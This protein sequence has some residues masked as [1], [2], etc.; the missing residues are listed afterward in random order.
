MASSYAVS[1]RSLTKPSQIPEKNP[2]IIAVPSQVLVTGASGF[3]GAQ[4]V[5]QLLAKG[6]RVR[7]TVR[8]AGKPTGLEALKRVELFTADLLAQG[9]FD[10]A[11]YRC[12]C[13]FHTASPYTLDT[14]NPQGDLV[15][16]AVNGTVNVLTACM[17]AAS[18]K[19]VVLT[20]S[21]AAITDEASADHVLTEADW[22]VK[23][24]LK[25]N[26]YYY[27]KVCAERAAW[28]FMQ[29]QRPEFDLVVINP[30]MVIGPSVVPSLN[31]SNR[32]F[33]DLIKGT[34]PAIFNLTW[35]F[36]DV[37][38]VADAHIRALETPSANGRY[39]IAGDTVSMRS[40]VEL[41]RNNGYQR[42]QLPKLGLDSS[43]GN[44]AIRLLSYL[45][46]P[47][48]GSYLRTHVGREPRYDTSKAR[49]ELGVTFRPAKQSILE[50]VRDLARWGH[51]P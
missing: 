33:V 13:V 44:I 28:Q 20:S 38:D 8:S 49:L 9:A 27:S 7:G 41:L 45:K 39:I 34:Y 1:L 47:G 16:P 31:T 22:N 51:L 25:R 32:L 14:K 18:V 36:V 26:P 42:S 2:R 19:R 24:S 4:L 23:S 30:F 48:V 10:A 43:A 21:M 35:G 37:R 6:Y 17:K 15:D 11:V 46:S 12:A 29:E 40:I 50:T 3:V 5:R